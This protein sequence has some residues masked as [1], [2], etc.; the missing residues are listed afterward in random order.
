MQEA[1]SIELWLLKNQVRLVEETTA[2]P[3]V[4]D[5]AEPE[6]EDEPEPE[7]DDLDYDGEM[8]RSSAF[9]ELHHISDA[10]LAAE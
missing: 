7:V 1:E 4:E 2:E 5:E 3:E 8:P 10:P 9:S 6:V